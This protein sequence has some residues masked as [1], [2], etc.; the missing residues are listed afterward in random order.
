MS[1][2]S[3]F[4]SVYDM[5]QYDVDYDFWIEGIIKIAKANNSNAKTMLEL[6]CGT[7][8]LA[9]G[10]AKKGFLTEGIDISEDML[11]IAQTK[12]YE[13]GAKIRFYNQ[14][15]IH[16]NTKKRYDVIFCMCDG[17]NYVIDDDEMKKVFSNISSHLNPEGVLI[18]DLSSKYKLSEVIG[19][20]TFAETFE[21]EAYIWENEYEAEQNLLRFSLTLFKDDGGGYI[22]HEE[23]HVQRAYE[24]DEILALAS[25]NFDTTRIMD[26]D[27][28]DA[29]HEKS[30]RLCFV[31]TPKK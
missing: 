16:F 25:A 13:C 14:D 10:L 19:N 20:H 15:M 2:Y 6:A 23:N 21:H 8:T 5:M 29:P 3:E 22:R 17:M 4:A 18:F 27:T 11:T 12:A 26:G 31:M 9:I 7:G 24:I 1:I 30:N 28:F